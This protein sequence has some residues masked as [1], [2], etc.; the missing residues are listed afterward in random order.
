MDNSINTTIPAHSLENDVMLFE[1]F[2]DKV[3]SHDFLT[4][5]CTHII[6]HCGKGQFRMGDTVYTIERND[7]VVWVPGTKISDIMASPDFKAHILLISRTFLSE[8]RPDNKLSI[9]GYLYALKYPM[10]RLSDNEMEIFARNYDTIGKRIT[11]TDNIYYR[12]IIINLAHIII[13]DIFNVYHNEFKKR[14]LS[15]EGSG[16]FEKFL[17]LVQDHCFTNREVAF[18]SD[19]LHVSPKYLS[20]VCKKSSGKTASDWIDQYAIE[21]IR[22]LLKN[23]RLSIKDIA[24][25]MNFSTQS[26]FGRYVKRLLG[27][28]PSEYRENKTEDSP[29]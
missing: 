26:F 13:Y 20:V 22:V 15:N 17:I 8:M 10:F 29:G 11:D 7:F 5:Y 3:F 9:E 12:D 14:A 2:S 18:Y 28:S 1:T 21:H 6:C 27:V 16:L 4:N 23:D 24:N 19:K 25:Q